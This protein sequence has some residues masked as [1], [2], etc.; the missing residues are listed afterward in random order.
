MGESVVLQAVVA[1]TDMSDCYWVMTAVPEPEEEG[2]G[3]GIPGD[4]SLVAATW[5]VLKATYR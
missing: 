2:P 1:S 5:S 3:D 4:D